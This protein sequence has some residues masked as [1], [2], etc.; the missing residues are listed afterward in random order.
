LIFIFFCF[1]KA[2]KIAIHEKLSPRPIDMAIGSSLNTSYACFALFVVCSTRQAVQN[3]AWHLL[4]EKRLRDYRLPGIT[5]ITGI[6]GDYDIEKRLENIPL[7]Y[8]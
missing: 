1:R 8:G 3:D 7:V 5:L 4:P 6:R 2:I